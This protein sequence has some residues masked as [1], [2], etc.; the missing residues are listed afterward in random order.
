[1][2]CIA[3]GLCRGLYSKEMHTISC[4]RESILK[5]FTESDMCGRRVNNRDDTGGA[6]FKYL[7][8]HYYDIFTA[9]FVEQIRSWEEDGL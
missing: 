1:M 3:N 8:A 6:V 9:Q 4:L 2:T 7:L 5:Q